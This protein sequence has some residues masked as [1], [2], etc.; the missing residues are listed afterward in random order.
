MLDQLFI[1][2][3]TILEPTNFLAVFFGVVFGI[4]IGA[5]PG[6]TSPMGVALLIPFTYTMPKVPAICMLVALYC[7]GTFGGSI[8]AILVHAPGTPAAAATTFD[9]YPLAQKGMA[10]KA[11]GMACISSALGGLFSVIVLIL[12]APLLADIAIKFGPPEYFALAVFGLSMI[13]S[14]GSRSVLKNLIGG[15]IGVLISCVGMDEISGFGR[16]DF[17]ITHLMDGISFIPVMIGLFA[18]TEVFRQAEV[19]IRKVVIDRKISGLLPSWQ[20]IK[21]VKTTMIRSGLIGTFIGIL[22]AEGGTVASFIGYNEAKRFSKHPEKFGTGILEGVAAP[23]TA[24]NAATGGAMI[25]TLALGIPGSG[26]T[27]VILGALLVHGMRPGP[28]LFM[29]HTHVVYSVFV[30]MFLANLIFLVVGL[31]GA[32]IFSNILRVPNYVLSPII[33]V[34]CVVGTYALHNNMADVWIML[35]CG[36][37]GYKMREYGFAAAPIVLGVVLGELIEIS[38]RRS[39]IVFGNNPLVFFTRPWAATFIVLTVLGLCSPA[40]RKWIEN[41]PGK[42]QL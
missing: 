30:G 3:L 29:Q 6:L 38:L 25:P 2:L 19:G 32:K 27:A 17:G 7:G 40:I 10:G 42:T 16:F 37:I 33:L 28:L 24:N 20:D 8:S 22:P 36:I 18:A 11:L 13:S 41:R 39:L 5:L 9:G 1:G 12:L 15:A 23:E 14:L 34:L 21:A 31:L 4:I 35:I 26:T